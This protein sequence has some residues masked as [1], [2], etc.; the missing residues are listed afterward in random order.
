MYEARL[1]TIATAV[2]RGEAIYRTHALNQMIERGITRMVVEAALTA[3]TEIIEDYPAEPRGPC[4]LV[5]G[6]VKGRAIH[7]VVSYPPRLM[8]ITA[9]WPDSRPDEW[10][11]DFRRRVR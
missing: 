11:P 3:D 10:S 2:R 6:R 9:Y 8:I 1:A 7:I 5:L 4:C